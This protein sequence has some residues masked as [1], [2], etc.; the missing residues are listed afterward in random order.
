MSGGGWSEYGDYCV[1]LDYK[2]KR[3]DTFIPWYVRLWRPDANSPLIGPSLGDESEC[4]INAGIN[5]AFTGNPSQSDRNRLYSFQW[6]RNE[7]VPDSCAQR[8]IPLDGPGPRGY[9]VYHVRRLGPQSCNIKATGHAMCAL[10]HGSATD[11]G[12]KTWGNWQ[13]FQYGDSK[14]QVGGAN[15]NYQI[16]RPIAPNDTVR[17]T[18]SYIV[19]FASDLSSGPTL[20]AGNKIVTFDIPHVGNPTALPYPE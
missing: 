5:F 18:I 15:C 8:Y 16:P 13:F 10:Y 2:P 17:V 20:A 3:S 19:G 12:Y 14:I 7:S 9:P 1:Q 11:S 4:T 6:K